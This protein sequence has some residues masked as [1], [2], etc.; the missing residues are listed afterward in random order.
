MDQELIIYTKPELVVSDPSARR[1]VADWLS[2]TDNPSTIR[3]YGQDIAHYAAWRGISPAAAG[4]LLVSLTQAELNAEVIAWRNVLRADIKAGRL[5]VSTAQRRLVAIRSLFRYARAVG[6]THNTVEIKGFRVTAYKDTTVHPASLTRKMI[7]KVEGNSTGALRDRAILWVLGTAALRR[8]ELTN[9]NIG[10]FDLDRGIVT[11]VMKGEDDTTAVPLP[12]Q[13]VAAVRA[14]FAVHPQ[15]GVLSA[16]AFVNFVPIESIRGGRLT[17]QAIYDITRKYGH[18]A[19]V[20]GV[21]P[22]LIRHGA[23]DDVARKTK[24]IQA[25]RA[26]SRHRKLDT[27][28]IYL[29]NSEDLARKMADIAA[30]SLDGEDVAA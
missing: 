20:E 12:R 21:R 16:P 4:D 5:A 9:L 24:D 8:F 2:A 18:L 1:I 15:S 19:G 23:I 28:A 22:H 13:T 27:V 3:A 25:T 29:H 14:W 6:L 30:A 10:S 26:F 17:G 7:Q 11:I